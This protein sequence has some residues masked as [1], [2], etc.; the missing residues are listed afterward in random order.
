MGNILQILHQMINQQ[1]G[2]SPFVLPFHSKHVQSFGGM[3]K[4]F[5]NLFS[6]DNFQDKEVIWSQKIFQN[7]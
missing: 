5:V 7:Q 6:A 3:I 4:Y 2:E 1:H